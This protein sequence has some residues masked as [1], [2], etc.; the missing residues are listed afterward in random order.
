[1]ARELFTDQQWQ[2][3][4]EAPPQIARA[5]AAAAGSDRQSE[6]ELAAFLDLVER[7]RGD[8]ADHQL[9]GL[10][11]SDVHT[12]LAAGSLQATSEDPVA[13]LSVMADDIQARAIRLWLLDVA[14]TVAK[15]ASEGG[16]LGFRSEEVSAPEREAIAAISDALGLSEP[17]PAAESERPAD[18]S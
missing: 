7:T 2:Q 12:L 16:I 15:A 1:M 18:D 17:E 10:L 9:L 3:L 8:V 13:I 4:L 6:G 14:R 11:A 5:V